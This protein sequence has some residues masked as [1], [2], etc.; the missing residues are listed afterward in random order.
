L[1]VQEKLQEREKE[2][3]GNMRSFNFD[4]DQTNEYEKLLRKLEADIR[5]YIKVKYVLFRLNI[6]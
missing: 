1:N 6:N 4:E 5:T 2:T 3:E